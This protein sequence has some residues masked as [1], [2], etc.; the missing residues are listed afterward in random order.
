[1]CCCKYFAVALLFD[2]G[3]VPVDIVVVDDD[4]VVDDI[5]IVSFSLLMLSLLCSL[6][7]NDF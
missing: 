7:K 2:P 1:V 6:Y 5:G 4:V 3:D